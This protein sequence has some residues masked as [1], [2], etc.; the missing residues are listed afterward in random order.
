MRYV[1]TKKV[2]T[3]F[4][5]LQLVSGLQTS[6]MPLWFRGVSNPLFE[7]VPGLIW[8]KDVEFESNYV[9]AFLVNF[10]AYVSQAPAN[11][12]E[13]YSLMQ[14]HGL[15]TRLLDWCRSPLH[16]LFFALTQDPD[17][18]GDRA[19][20][21]LQPHELNQQ[22]VGV[23][24]VFCPGALESRSIALP[25]GEVIDLDAYLPEALDPKDHY[26]IPKYPIAIESPLTHQRI[27][28]QMG[29]FTVHGSSCE[30]IEEFVQDESKTLAQFVLNTSKNG[31][32][33]F[34]KPLLAW[35]INEETIY[36]DLDSLS[37]RIRRE[38]GQK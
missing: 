24:S 9:H 11:P 32:E 37:S 29:C 10:K 28:G 15:P 13:T 33:Y 34:L 35:G 3:I 26:K 8:R 27:R 14:H 23:N 38:Q 4:E 25:S 16:A 2:E 7:L 6:G 22:C 5:F 12:W 17:I 20:W 21:M 30:P 19:V 36:Q 1:R 18:R 31:R